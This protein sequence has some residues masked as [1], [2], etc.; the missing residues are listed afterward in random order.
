MVIALSRLRTYASF[1]KIEHTVFSLPLIFAGTLLSTRGSFAPS[2]GLLILLA[3]IG[4]RAMGMGLNRLIDAEIDAR[5]PRT[6]RRELPSGAMGRG[7]AWTLT[8]LSGV[9][10]LASAAALGPVCLTWS[11][12][13]VALFVM[14]PYLKRFTSLAHVGLGIAWSMGPLAGWLAASRDASGFGEV[15]WLWAF[16]LLW[17]SGF[18][19]IYATMDEAFD[20]QE[21]L[22][23]LPARIG[24]RGA[25]RVAAFLHVMACL[26][27]VLLWKSQLHTPASLAWLAAAGL[28]LV[29]EHAVAGKSPEFAFFKLNAAIGFLVFAM[30]LSGIH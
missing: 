12:V 25:L 26:C 2:L 10:Y 14:Y 5:N 21:K 11:P 9:L 22:Y 20:R 6:R 24:K 18:D 30:V 7:E 19:V 3:A 16:A 13:P 1:V 27:L 15:G 23:S 29:W 17:V 28:V 8:L 4:A